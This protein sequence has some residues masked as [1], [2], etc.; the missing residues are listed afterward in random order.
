M[1][2]LSVARLP[3]RIVP[4]AISVRLDVRDK[5]GHDAAWC[6]RRVIEEFGL[7]L[8]GAIEA[9]GDYLVGALWEPP[10][11]TR[12]WTYLMRGVAIAHAVV[13]ARGEQVFERQGG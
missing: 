12:R 4:A 10:L 1:A 2:H 5:D 3:L 7:D 8:A 11:F 6:L 9:R 13:D